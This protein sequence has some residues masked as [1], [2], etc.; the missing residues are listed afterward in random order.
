M[1]RKCLVCG[2]EFNT[3]P[4]WNNRYCSRSCSAKALMKRHTITCAY[5]GKVISVNDCSNQKYCSKS[6][7]D[8]AKRGVPIA[9]QITKIC[10]VC[11][12][13]FT[14]N[15]RDV[16][17][18]C[19]RECSYEGK[20]RY[21]P[22]YSE[23]DKHRLSENLKKRWE[24]PDFRQAAV[25]RMK[26]NN[27]VYMPGVAEKAAQTR[28]QNASYHNNFKYGNGKISH[29]ERL[30]YDKL[31]SLGFAYNCAIAIGSIKKQFPE[32]HYPNNYKPDFVN[33]ENKLCI[34]IDGYGHS[35]PKEK[36]ADKKKEECLSLLGF[37]TIRFTHDQIDSGV[38]DIWLNS[39][40]SNT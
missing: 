12:T 4:S 37:T 17:V 5:C 16:K 40:Q 10:P 9:P 2:K 27:P 11:G 13:Q 33:F 34:E 31:I 20:K 6:C 3:C 1:I 19:S 38:F 25:D 36:L 18:F 21:R 39:Y 22:N 32:K 28:K 29:Y 15:Y 14:V 26:T 23:A 30:V 7:A 24:D 8:S 35:S